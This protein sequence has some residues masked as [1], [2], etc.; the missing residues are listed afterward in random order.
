MCELVLHH[1]PRERAG[2]EEV[3]VEPDLT[4]SRTR[5]RAALNV[6]RNA[7]GHDAPVEA[8]RVERAGDFGMLARRAAGERVPAPRGASGRR[9][10]HRRDNDAE[11][12]KER[13]LHVSA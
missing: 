7:R 3:G 9:Q 8:A 2:V 13:T 1:A 4:R 5:R 11:Q 6:N 10:Q 12:E